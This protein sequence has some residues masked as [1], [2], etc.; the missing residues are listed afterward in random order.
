MIAGQI[1]DPTFGNRRMSFA[2]SPSARVSRAYW[3]AAEQGDQMEPILRGLN[4]QLQRQRSSRLQS[5]LK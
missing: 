4:L 5:F 1:S 3:L 2:V